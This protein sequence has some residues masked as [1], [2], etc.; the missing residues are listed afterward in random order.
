MDKETKSVEELSDVELKA[1]G[2]EKMNL[3]NLYKNELEMINVELNK[4][5]ENTKKEPLKDK[6]K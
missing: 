6:K 4:R 2:F 3:I 1:I 5:F